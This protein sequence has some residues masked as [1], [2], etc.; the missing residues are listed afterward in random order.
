MPAC[1]LIFAAH[2]AP[3]ISVFGSTA[4]GSRKQD[5]DND[6]E[7]EDEDQQQQQQHSE[8]V[9]SGSEAGPRSGAQASSKPGH[10]GKGSSSGSIV[11]WPGLPAEEGGR[12]RCAQAL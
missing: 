6:D 7:G 3:G 12:Q 2:A 10:G 1:P 5:D 11:Y 9:R 8:R 4:R